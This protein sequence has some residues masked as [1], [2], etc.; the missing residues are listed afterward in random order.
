MAKKRTHLTALEVER[1][2]NKARIEAGFS[3]KVESAAVKTMVEIG[4]PQ[5]HWL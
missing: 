5:S 2:L 1:E 4:L 3:S